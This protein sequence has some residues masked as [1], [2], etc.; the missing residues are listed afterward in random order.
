MDSTLAWKPCLERQEVMSKQSDE[1]VVIGAG[2]GGLAAATR[3]AKSGFKVRVFEA[4]P[5]PGGKCRT[6]NIDG[7][8]FD[9]GPSLLT[10]PAVYRDLFLKSGKHLGQELKVTPVEPAFDYFFSDG[11][12][13]T[14]PSSSRAGTAAAIA[15][16][17]GQKSAAE[18][19]NLMKRAEKMWAVSREPFVESE[20]GTLT[21]LISRPRIFVDLFTIAP[22]RSLR[23][24]VNR[25]IS[26]PRLRT[27]IDRYAT[28]TGSDPRSAPAVLL[29]I[30]YVEMVFGAWHVGGGIGKLGEVL[31]ERAQN[32]GAQI[33]YNCPVSEILTS[34]GKVTGVRLADGRV[35]E[36]QTVVSNAD[37]ELTYGKLLGNLPVARKEKQKI[38]R[39]EPSLSGFYLTIGL[40][41]K[42]SELNHHTVSFPDDYDA[43]FNSVFKNFQPV[44]DP[45]LYICSPADEQM[46]PNQDL[47]NHESLFVLVNAPRHSTD[48]KGFDWST[49]GVA[50]KYADHLVDLLVAKGFIDRERIDV[51][52]YGSPL[53]IQNNHLAPGG[54]IYGRS[55]N[56]A[57][58]AFKRAKNRSPIDGLYLVGG[59]AHPGGGLPLVGLSGE[60]V[61]GIIS[62]RSKGNNGLWAR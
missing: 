13:L 10:L 29:T 45:T 36:S 33:E 18:W 52:A 5:Q 35:I 32:C 57:R 19:E 27:L 30:P 14:L 53:Q 34:D 9:T 60:I 61:A 6:I 44:V 40:K 24:L 54:S 16:S 22:W 47:A 25:K 59:S 28:Y 2:M 20:L 15:K 17:F 21:S 56:G 12:R 49:P 42:R 38:L 37:S 41:G 8:S 4:G 55:S 3:L 23:S 11:T 48:G 39:S 51:F 43:E 62:Q 46:V 50:E 1:V 7:Y 26:D 31:A 58:A